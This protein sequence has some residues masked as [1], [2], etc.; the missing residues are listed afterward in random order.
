MPGM[1]Q[2]PLEMQIVFWFVF[3]MLS[4][5]CAMVVYWTK[6]YID[7]QDAR[8]ER[9]EKKLSTI[10]EN[11]TNTSG[12]I[13]SIN[14]S[15]RMELKEFEKQIDKSLLSYKDEIH[16]INRELSVAQTRMIVLNENT[17]KL[18]KTTNT[19]VTVMKDQVPKITENHEKT[20]TL[21]LTQQKI[22]TIVQKLSDKLIK[23]S[24]KPEE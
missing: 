11:L 17:D 6:R 5:L 23:I 9:H 22:V 21:E 4:G 19:L 16:L 14:I 24:S 18:F 8:L 7:A 13:K 20:Q 10:T 2:I 3:I 12:E 15:M 1:N